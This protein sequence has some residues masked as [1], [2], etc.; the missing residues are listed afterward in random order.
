[1]NLVLSACNSNS[2]IYT[3]NNNSSND[4]SLYNEILN[5]I[6]QYID[7]Y[8]PGD[9][10]T[11][12]GNTVYRGYQLYDIDNNG[13]KELFIYRASAYGKIFIES[14]YTIKDGKVILLVL[15]NS[16]FLNTIYKTGATRDEVFYSLSDGRILK[17]SYHWGAIDGFCIYDLKNGTTDDYSSYL[18]EYTKNNNN[19]DERTFNNDF[20]KISSNIGL[21]NTELLQGTIENGGGIGINE[22]NVLSNN[23]DSIPYSSNSSNSNNRQFNSLVSNID[24]A[25][26]LREYSDESN[27]D[28]IDKVIFGSNNGTPLEWVVLDRVGN[29]ALLISK[30]IIENEVYDTSLNVSYSDSYIRNYVNTVVYDKYFT[31]DEKKIILDTTIDNTSN[32]LFILSKDDFVK[33]FGSNMKN[34]KKATTHI[35]DELRMSRNNITIANKPGAW[36]HGNSSYWLRDTLGNGN[37][38]YVGYSGRLNTDGDIMTINDGIR[39]AMW[40][41]YK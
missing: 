35:T 19:I 41:T 40:I 6:E 8:D 34:N 2:N 29:K 9:D 10:L 37:A 13:V 24:S 25:M 16:T 23:S 21:F 26:L 38:M 27:I 39:P 5:S 18:N 31:E 30:L 28:S 33:Y 22:Q 7:L 17:V 36:Y 4:I 20:R 12:V 15:P 3:E 11:V 32:K 14:A 1:M